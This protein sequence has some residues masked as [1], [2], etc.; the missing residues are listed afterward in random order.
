[1]KQTNNS[2]TTAEIYTDVPCTSKPEFFYTNGLVYGKT[3]K[4][5]IQNAR[6]YKIP[7]PEWSVREHYYGVV[8]FDGLI[9]AEGS[10]KGTYDPSMK[11]DL[12][13]E[14]EWSPRYRQMKESETT[15]PNVL[16]D[17]RKFN[18]FASQQEYES[19]LAVLK[20]ALANCEY[21]DLYG[22]LDTLM[23][24]QDGK[25]I[26]II[27]DQK[28]YVLPTVAKFRKDAETAVEYLKSG[29]LDNET[30]TFGYGIYGTE[31]YNPEDH[32]VQVHYDVASWYVLVEPDCFLAEYIEE[33]LI[34]VVRMFTD[35]NMQSIKD[36][37]NEE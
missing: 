12:L 5:L 14:A 22:Y 36:F 24:R 13:K 10:Y 32:T 7:E 6:N 9:L 31:D 33:A 34:E 27:L 19:V 21:G 4:E 1:M 18:G 30:Y 3:V 17:I 25:G 16:N 8:V 11:A 28:E 29:R 23:V 20:T 2:K 15:T 35:E 37:F 26:Y